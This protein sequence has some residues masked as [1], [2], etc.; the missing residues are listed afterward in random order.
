MVEGRF[1][2]STSELTSPLNGI[3]LANRK[4][5]LESRQK[6]HKSIPIIDFALLTMIIEILKAP[7]SKICK[8]YPF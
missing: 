7:T 3:K 2:Y 5:A 1:T 4:F 8:T 6:V